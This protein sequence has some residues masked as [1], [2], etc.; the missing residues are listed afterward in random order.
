MKII[1]N[2]RISKAAKMIFTGEF[3]KLK[4]PNDSEV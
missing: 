2:F 1:P 4:P 3:M